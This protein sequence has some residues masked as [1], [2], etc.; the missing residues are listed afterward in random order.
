MYNIKYNIYNIK[1]YVYSVLT[2]IINVN[3][4]TNVKNESNEI[5]VKL[6]LNMTTAINIF[7]K[8]VIKEKDIPF[9][10]K[11]E[12]E[13]DMR[14]AAEELRKIENNEGNYKIYDDVKSFMEDLEKDDQ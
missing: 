4:P 1:E 13:K 10:L 6:G 3:V 7:L 9:E 11:L 14:E 8:K 5:F 12:A 2:L